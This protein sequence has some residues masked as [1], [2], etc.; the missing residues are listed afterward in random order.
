METDHD[1]ETL[2]KKHVTMLLGLILILENKYRT[3]SASTGPRVH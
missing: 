1:D 3:S 2:F